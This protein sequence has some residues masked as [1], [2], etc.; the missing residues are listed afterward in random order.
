MFHDIEVKW[1]VATGHGPP[2]ERW[3]AK[4][5]RPTFTDSFAQ[6]ERVD[7]QWWLIVHPKWSIRHRPGLREQRIRYKSARLAK[8]HL[9]A[10]LRTNWPTVERHF[11]IYKPAQSE[12]LTP[13]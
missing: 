2:V 6:V 4:V 10:W 9:V 3:F 5:E 7:G 1:S 8:R 11:G 13:G 12:A